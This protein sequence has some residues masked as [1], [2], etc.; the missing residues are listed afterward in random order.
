MSNSILPIPMRRL[1]GSAENHERFRPRYP[2]EVIPLIQRETGLRLGWKVADVG[3][4][5]GI[6]AR[7]LLTVGCVVE[8]VEPIGEMRCTAG[9]FLS[10]RDRFQ[11]VGAPAAVADES[12]DLVLSAQAI[13]WVDPEATR[14]EFERLLRPGGWVVM[15]WNVRQV[16]PTPVVEAYEDLL[17]AYATDY[18]E[19]SHEWVTDEG[20]GRFF[21]E[22]VWAGYS[23][24]N[25]QIFDYPGLAGR[26]LTSPYAPGKGQPNHEVMMEALKDIFDEHQVNGKVSFDCETMVCIGH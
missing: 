13:H 25:S 9:G 3:S 22:G 16:E 12:V 10:G 11:G 24:P 7:M 18:A 1:S 2:T 4:G 5:A 17:M 14:R 21:A 15:M 8:G 6:S 19:A 20:V 26:L 23:V